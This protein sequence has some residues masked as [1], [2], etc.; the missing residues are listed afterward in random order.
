MCDP[1]EPVRRVFCVFVRH[2]EVLGEP[3]AELWTERES[4]FPGGPAGHSAVS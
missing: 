4:E 2:R 1:T 3:D